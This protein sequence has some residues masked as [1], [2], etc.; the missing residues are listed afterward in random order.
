LFFAILAIACWL[1]I[2]FALGL[3]VARRRAPDSGP[4]MLYGDLAAAALWIAAVVAV[5]TMAGSL[6]FSEVA[7][8]VPCKLCW[9]QRIALYPLAITLTV[10]ALRQDSRVW[11]YVVPQAL[12]G[13]GFAI[14]HTQLQAFPQQHSSFCTITEPCTVRYV[15]EFGFMSLPLMALTAFATIVTFVLIARSAPQA[16]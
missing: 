11:W 16:S 9:Y 6:Y 1:G 7:H 8:F 15:W 5:V 2:A 3:V 4:A 14:Y 10:G 12:I 13:A